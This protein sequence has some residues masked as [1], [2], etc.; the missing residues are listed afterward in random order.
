M[1]HFHIV[2]IGSNQRLHYLKEHFI[3]Y[4]NRKIF[5][6]N[7][8]FIVSLHCPNFLIKDIDL[9]QKVQYGDL[10]SVSQVLKFIEKFNMFII[11][12]KDFEKRLY[13]YFG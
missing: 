4:I 10:I 1:L 2:F 8:S 3:W 6:N 5:L 9:T 7:F 13:I 11:Y 12:K